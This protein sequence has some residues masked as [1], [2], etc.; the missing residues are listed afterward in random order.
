[1][2]NDDLNSL[3]LS[4]GDIIHRQQIVQLLKVGIAQQW[5]FSFVKKVKSRIIAHSIR[6]KS[7]HPDEG[8]F[9]FISDAG[10]AKFS[11]GE[12]LLFRGQS[13]GLSV[14]FQSRLADSVGD[15]AKTPSISHFELPYKVA[16]TQ[17]RKTL[18]VNLETIM[19]V[20]VTLYMVN[21]AIVEGAVMH[22]SSSGAKFRVEQNL[23]K[24]FRNPGLIDACKIDFSDDFELQSGIQLIGMLN[25]KDA[26]VSF[27]RCQFMQLQTEDEDRLEKFID[28]ALNLADELQAAITE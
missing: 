23:E 12:T 14:V 20:P 5:T 18:R 25:D 6:L 21:G 17:L 16:C 1:M 13:G 26:E 3:N 8:L 11:P 24:E 7:V 22:I 19:R 27:L 9:S 2:E 4:D 15:D 10:N 28:E